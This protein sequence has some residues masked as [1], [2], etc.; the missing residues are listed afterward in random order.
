MRAQSFQDKGQA[1]RA[2]VLGMR[3]QQS[4]TCIKQSS[5][6]LIQKTLEARRSMKAY[7]EHANKS[8]TEKVKAFLDLDATRFKIKKKLLKE[9]RLQG[10]EEQKFLEFHGIDKAIRGRVQF[11]NDGLHQLLT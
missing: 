7:V 4:G 8:N 10:K 3:G 5:K 9:Y 11:P 2:S 1:D 6:H